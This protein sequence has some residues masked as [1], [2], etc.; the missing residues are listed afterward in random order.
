MLADTDTG[1]E[2]SDFQT[3]GVTAAQFAINRK[4]G[5]RQLLVSTHCL[6]LILSRNMNDRMLGLTH[7]YNNNRK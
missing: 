3:E 1:T 5:K 4:V 6:S 7:V 2:I